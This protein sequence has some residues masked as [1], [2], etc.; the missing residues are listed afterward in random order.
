MTPLE[1]EMAR[2]LATLAAGGIR[3]CDARS[4]VEEM[5]FEWEDWKPVWDRCV[6]LV[7]AGKPV[8]DA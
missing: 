2:S 7:K 1:K 5:G 4:L 8:G 6:E 3:E